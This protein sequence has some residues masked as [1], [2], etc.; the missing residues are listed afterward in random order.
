[1]TK[2]VL[3]KVNEWED[4]LKNKSVELLD[5]EEEEGSLIAMDIDIMV[6]GT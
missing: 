4:L 6:R 5:V 2:G 3:N 1:M